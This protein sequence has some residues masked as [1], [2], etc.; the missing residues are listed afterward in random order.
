[1]ADS[2]SLHD[3]ARHCA[4]LVAPHQH[5]F[6][7]LFGAAYKGIPLVTA[8]AFCLFEKHQIRKPLAF[9]RKEAKR[10]GEGGQLMGGD[11]QG[12]RVLL[13]DDVLTTGAALSGIVPLIE[14]SGGRVS[15]MLVLFDRQEVNLEGQA[16]RSWLEKTHSIKIRA[17]ACLQDVFDYCRLHDHNVLSQAQLDILEAYREKYGSTGPPS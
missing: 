3:T 1:M 9:N 10:H 2:G 17:L 11:V 7:V 6:D 8:T 16:S 5:R 13:I 15:E 4:A 14:K 12:Q